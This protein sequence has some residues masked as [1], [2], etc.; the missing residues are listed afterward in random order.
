MSV[1]NGDDERVIAV[2]HNTTERPTLRA[3]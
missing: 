3:A 2:V 1:N